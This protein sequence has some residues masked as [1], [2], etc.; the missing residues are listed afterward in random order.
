[1]GVLCLVWCLEVPVDGGH[2]GHLAP[3]L[4]GD[5]A[6][7]E[8]FVGHGLCVRVH[9]HTGSVAK[10]RYRVEEMKNAVRC[11]CHHALLLS[12]YLQVTGFIAGHH[13]VFNVPV[14]TRAELWCFHYLITCRQTVSSANVCNFT[15]LFPKLF[16]CVSFIFIL[17]FLFVNGQSFFSCIFFISSHHFSWYIAVNFIHLSFGFVVI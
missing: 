5:A 15:C 12:V 4:A 14:D 17:L 6:Q 11:S 8:A 1:M 16:A 10:T 9:L 3:L 2:G 7:F 13:S